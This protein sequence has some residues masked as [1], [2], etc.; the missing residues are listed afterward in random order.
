MVIVLGSARAR[1]DAFDEALALSRSHV[2]HSRG[3]P[4]CLSHD[5]L[6]DPDDAQ[7]LVFVE[8]WADTAALQV[9]FGIPES[10]TFVRALAALCVE[11]PRMTLHDATELPMP[12]PKMGAP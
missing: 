5:V 1:A 8:R 7:R 6:R 12:A 3:E 10:R 4:G 11:P 2:A 9:H